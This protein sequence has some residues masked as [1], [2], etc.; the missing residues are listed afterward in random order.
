MIDPH[1]VHGADAPAISHAYVRKPGVAFGLDGN[2]GGNANPEMARYQHDAYC[3]ALS[4]CGVD[5]RA[6]RHDPQFPD[7]CR[8]NDL[9]IVTPRVA[10]IAN[11]G[12]RHARQGEQQFAASLLAASR[13]LKFITAPG[14]LDAGDVARIGQHYIIGL[15]ARTNHEGAAQ[16]AFY[17]TEAGYHTTILDVGARGER[18]GSAVCDLGPYTDG[19]HRIMLRED[20]SRHYAF[21]AYEKM[22]VSCDKSGALDSMMINGT[23][24]VP[25]GYR[26]VRDGIRKLGIAVQDI[27]MSEFV[28]T[29]FGLT[30]LSLRL[31]AR[32]HSESV[33]DL[34]HMRQKRVA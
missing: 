25:V 11:F 28:K 17:L 3:R 4:A 32:P 23:L 16:L 2:N 14:I 34:T 33:I 18:L 20:L 12:E 29:G 5:V 30:S 21:I 22:I 15:S 26:D 6:L 13:A 19:Q 8:I 24:L 31:P 1:F 27:D 10:V 7:S 9:A